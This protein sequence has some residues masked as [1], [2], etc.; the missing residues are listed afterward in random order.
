MS[1]NALIFPSLRVASNATMSRFFQQ[2]EAAPDVFEYG[3]ATMARELRFRAWEAAGDRNPALPCPD[4]IESA[5]PGSRCHLDTPHGGMDQ[6]EEILAA[7]PEPGQGR[8]HRR[9]GRERHRA[10]STLTDYPAGTNLSLRAE[11]LH[12]GAQATLLDPDAHR[13]PAFLTNSPRWH[14]PTQQQKA[15]P[16]RQKPRKQP[17]RRSISYRTNNQ[18]V[19]Q[20][21]SLV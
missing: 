6:R 19:R 20:N 9:V 11:P 7:G 15:D 2:A 3:F 1:K 4:R 14:G 18:P 16:A 5:H 10:F 13:M 21:P 17:G 12:S 8:T